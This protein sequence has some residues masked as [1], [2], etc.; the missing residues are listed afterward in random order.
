MSSAGCR[1]LG[2]QPPS[3]PG[4]GHCSRTQAR[5]LVAKWF[6]KMDNINKCLLLLL[7]V[8]LLQSAF[9]FVKIL[10][11][12]LCSPT[13]PTQGFDPVSSS[14]SP[15]S[16]FAL[17]PCCIRSLWVSVHFQVSGVSGLVMFTAV[18]LPGP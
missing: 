7:P 11:W 2:S 18:A 12:A 14:A 1:V 15:L 4:W 6:L 9:L 17:S 3:G 10:G 5:W 16:P 13:L 8:Q